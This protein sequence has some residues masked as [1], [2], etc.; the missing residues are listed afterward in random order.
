VSLWVLCS[1]CL[2]VFGA[3]HCNGLKYGEFGGHS[4]A[5]I[6]QSLQGL[7]TGWTNEGLEFESR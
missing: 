5:V 3:W 4:V 1:D 6:A 2:S 7:T